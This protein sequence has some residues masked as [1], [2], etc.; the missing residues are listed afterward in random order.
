MACQIS[1]AVVEI[2]GLTWA[3][4]NSNGRAY[5]ETF[6][7]E[8]TEAENTS[9]LKEALFTMPTARVTWVCAAYLLCYVGAEV[10]LGG[11]IVLFMID[12]RHGQKFASGMSAVGFWLG[13][14]IGR[15]VLGFVT[16]RIGVKLATSVGFFSPL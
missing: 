7:E 5:R 11:W 13:I 16:P 2:G 14:T 3:F 4:W 9:G 1:L 6:K 15:V 10:A 12:V 8:E